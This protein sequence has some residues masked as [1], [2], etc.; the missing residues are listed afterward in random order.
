MKANEEHIAALHLIG[1]SFVAHD[2]PA[3]IE[4]L[5]CQIY[6]TDVSSV[7]EARY[8]VFVTGS[9]EKALPPNYDALKMHIKRVNFQSRIWKLALMPVMQ[10]PEPTGNGWAVNEED[11]TTVQWL[12]GPYA[13]KEI[14]K[15]TKCGCKTTACK[16]GRC[17]CLKVKLRCTALCSCSGCG[18]KAEEL[19]SDE[20]G[21]SDEDNIDE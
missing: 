8:K 1:N 13:P 16:G 5:V 14:L 2:V 19:E 6:N 15:T 9:S 10:C 7:N 11:L 21:E 17:A 4:R 20:D 18:N 3:P 12:E